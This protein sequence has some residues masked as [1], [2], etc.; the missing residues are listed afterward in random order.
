MN[1]LLCVI[2]KEKMMWFKE[3]CEDCISRKLCK[4]KDQEKEI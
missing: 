2:A 3:Y 1:K 4:L